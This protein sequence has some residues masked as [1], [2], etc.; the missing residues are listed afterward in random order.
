MAEFVYNNKAHTGTKVL[1]FEVNSGQSPRMGFEMR[2]K[3]KFEGAEKFAK[4]IKE[5]Q[6]EAKVV[7]GKAQENMRR[8]AD[9]HRA[10]AVGYKVRN[11]VLLSTKDLKWQ[12]V[13]QHLEKLVE[14]F[15][16]PYKIKAIISS[17]V[18]ELELPATVKIHLVVNVSQ[19]KQYIDQVDGQRKETPQ[20]VVIEGEEEWEVEKILNKRKIRGK[21]KF[22]VWWKGFIAE[23]DTWE[24]RENL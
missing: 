8:Y 6:E 24:S 22:L 19:I 12:I 1:P 20:P 15:V 9:R 13:G 4:R 5:V 14:W 7:L 11:L 18:V 2:K 17:N 16:G 23:E 10:E 21:D 3:G